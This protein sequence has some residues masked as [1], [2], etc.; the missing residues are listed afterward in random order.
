MFNLRHAV[1]D[2]L[3]LEAD[4]Q[5]ESRS[6]LVRAL[7]S[8]RQLPRIVLSGSAPDVLL[9]ETVYSTAA[10]QRLQQSPAARAERAAWL[11]VVEPEYGDAQYDA[12]QGWQAVRERVARA[13]Y[14]EYRVAAL[15]FNLGL[16][17]AD[18]RRWANGWLTK[19]K[20]AAK[21]PARQD[22]AQFARVFVYLT[23]KSAV[24]WETACDEQVTLDDLVTASFGDARDGGPFDGGPAIDDR[25]VHAVGESYRFLAVA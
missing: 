23:V 19:A 5:L 15:R 8:R 6:P 22:N 16:L 18:L 24:E 3:L 4:A 13:L 10:A 20:A 9:D 7:V 17:P 12:A 14:A 2:L 25:P 11:A 1:L 21:D